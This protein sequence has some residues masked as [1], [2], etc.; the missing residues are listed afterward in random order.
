MD[1]QPSCYAIPNVLT[2]R[3]PRPSPLGTQFLGVGQPSIWSCSRPCQSRLEPDLES[4]GSRDGLLDFVE[5]Y[6]DSTYGES[7]AGCNH[8]FCNGLRFTLGDR[9]RVHGP[10]AVREQGGTLYCRNGWSTVL[11]QEG[12]GLPHRVS[13][14]T[15]IDTHSA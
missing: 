6:R 10:G 15:I 8:F 12:V 14:P 9:G 4:G 7:S 13:L 1:E 5:A 11:G 3:A 2:P